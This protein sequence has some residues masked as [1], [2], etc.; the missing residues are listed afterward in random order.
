MSVLLVIEPVVFKADI[1]H[2]ERED[3]IRGR[4]IIVDFKFTNICQTL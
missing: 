4:C 2:Q 3:V 1:K